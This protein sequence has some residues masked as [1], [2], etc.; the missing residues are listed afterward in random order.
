MSL[1]QKLFG[2]KIDII[3][4][5]H[6]EY[7][8]F[9]KLLIVL[10][11]DLEGNHPDNRKLVFVGDYC[12]RGPDS[13]SVI[14]LV[15]RFVE[16]GNAQAVLGNHELNLLQDNAKDGAGWYFKER[17][18]KDKKYMPFSVV[19]EEDKKI[20]YDFLKS[21]PIALENEE[22]RVVHATWDNKYINELR[23]V[24]LGQA[25]NYF[26]E[27]E[28]IINEE[29]SSSG[30]LAQYNE[31]LEQYNDSIEDEDQE[32]DFLNSVCE[33]NLAHQ[34]NN[35][36][37]VVTSGVEQRCETPFFASGK[38]RFVERYSWWDRYE[39]NIPVVVGHFW[40]KIKPI[41]QSKLKDENIF[42]DI[43]A[44]SWHGKNNDVFCVDFSVGGRFKERLVDKTGDNTMLAALQWPEQKLVLENG[45]IVELIN[46]KNN[47]DNCAVINLKTKII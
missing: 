32:V 38:W 15:K 31:D 45:E 10:G 37:R 44:N 23:E 13:P 6:G 41:P 27:K 43:P 18:K 39:D 36:I 20:I 11:Y 16:N 22:L 29:I 26:I 12:D 33:Y 25:I 21:L 2:G 14:K 47:V 4:D 1:I 8:A 3:G 7:E 35:P 17:E 40:R 30:L 28:K 46:Y 34:M 42:T 9:L 19:K 5:I 24:P